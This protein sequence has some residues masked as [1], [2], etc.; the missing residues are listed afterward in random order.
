MAIFLPGLNCGFMTYVLRDLFIFV[1]FVQIVAEKFPT[2]FTIM[3]V[4]AEVF[5]VGAVRGIIVV[6]TVFMMDSQELPV[7]VV[8]LFAALGAY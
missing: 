8:E 3:A 7:F 1:I 2:V 6:V 5:P 4:D